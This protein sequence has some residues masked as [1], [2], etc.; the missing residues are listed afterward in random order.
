MIVNPTDF[1]GPEFAERFVLTGL[2]KGG[3][4]TGEEAEAEQEDYQDNIAK[5]FEHD[6]LAESYR[7]CVNWM[8]RHLSSCEVGEIT[9][10]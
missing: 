5:M 7:T 1:D 3:A 6:S 8:S 10:D 4:S 2:F 9:E